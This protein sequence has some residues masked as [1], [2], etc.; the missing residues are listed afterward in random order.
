MT[1]NDAIIDNLK[2]NEMQY[3]NTIKQLNEALSACQH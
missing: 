2:N 3:Q 1:T